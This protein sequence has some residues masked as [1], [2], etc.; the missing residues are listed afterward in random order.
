MKQEHLPVKT[1]ILVG[2]PALSP[3]HRLALPTII[4][5]NQKRL[6]VSALIDSG[7]EQ[8]LININLVT[9]LSLPTQEI[10]PVS[11]AG[12]TGETLAQICLKTSNLHLIISGNHHETNDFLC[13]RVSYYSVNSG[14]YVAKET[15]F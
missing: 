5:I 15:R 3:P 4:Q 12:V 7:A 13:F 8:N 6:P 14:L 9:K 2:T 10:P 1:E 11:I